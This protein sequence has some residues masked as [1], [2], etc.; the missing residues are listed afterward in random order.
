MIE[1]WDITIPE[2]TGDEVRSAYIC[3]PEAYTFDTNQRFPVLYMFDGHNLFFDT[4]ATYGKS[5]GLKEYMEYTHTPL[6]IV[7]IE[8]NHSPDHGKITGKGKITMDWLTR[9]FKPYIDTHYRTL[10]DREHTFIA[11]SSMGGLMSIYALLHYNQFFSRAAALSPSL[12]I[13][14]NDFMQ[15]IR[16]SRPLSGSILYM[17]YGSREMKQHRKMEQSFGQAANLLLEKNIYLDCRIVPNGEHCEASWEKQ[18][19]FFMNTLMYDL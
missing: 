11:G 7:G 3:L 13:A 16:R 5:W 9:T 2:L 6:I 1:K 14:P 18:I 17:D 19:P 12:W 15:M 8:C 4:H 10:P